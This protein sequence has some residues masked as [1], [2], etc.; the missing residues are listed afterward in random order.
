[1][2]TG[3]LGSLHSWVAPLSQPV[4]PEC[5]LGWAWGAGSV[6]WQACTRCMCASLCTR[7]YLVCMSVCTCGC[8]SVCACVWA[9]TLVHAFMYEHVHMHVLCR[10][11]CMSMCACSCPGC[12]GEKTPCS[13][14]YIRVPPFL[15]W[16]LKIAHAQPCPSGQGADGQPHR[17]PEPSR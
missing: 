1:M 3:A 14:C 12:H 16:E 9:H 4:H 13:S 5:T 8:A 11:V 10:S 17:A 2:H 6:F 15:I 7:G